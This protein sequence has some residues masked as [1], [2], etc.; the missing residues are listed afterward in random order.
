MEYD[1]EIHK[2]TDNQIVF[3]IQDTES[4]G[5]S[6]SSIN[7]N[8]NALDIYTCNFEYSAANYWN[9]VYTLF[10]SNSASWINALNTVKTNSACWTNTYTTV[11]NLSAVWMK[12]ISLIFPYVFSSEGDEDTIISEVTSWVN[13]ALPISTGTCYN[14]IVGQELFIFSPQYSEINRTLSQEKVTGVRT[15][16]VP[17]WY[18]CRKG[19][20]GGYVYGKVDCGSLRVDIAVPDQ[21]VS[22]FVGL[23]YVVDIETG[24][25]RYDSTLYN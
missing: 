20:V 25:W 5:D 24:K 14:F 22:N 17:W 18:R 2:V 9:S 21:F 15:V 13:D 7:Y 10:N 16:K 3:P 4:I 12:P 6:L 11:K 1:R 19:T 8:F 23:K